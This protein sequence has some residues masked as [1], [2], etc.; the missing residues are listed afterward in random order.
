MATR[1][2]VE[3][4]R[5]N[6]RRS[7][8]PRTPEGKTIASRNATTLGLFTRELLL[9]DE[10]PGELEALRE[11][12]HQ[13]LRPTGVIERGC[14]ERYIVATWRLQRIMGAEAKIIAR[15]RTAG[16][17]SPADVLSNPDALAELEKLQ[18]HIS[19]LERA[20]DRA[21]NMLIKLQKR[22]RGND[23]ADRTRDESANAEIE[24]NS[25]PQPALEAHEPTEAR[26]EVDLAGEPRAS[27]PIEIVKTKP[28]LPARPS[29]GGGESRNH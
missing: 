8:G 19:S 22:R 28:I 2:Q 13:Q 7:T 27:S 17:P 16:W 23:R 29:A 6:A 15:W 1:R 3:A 24:A 12:T 5:L 18:K 20:I 14:V 21:L 10:D 26:M 25:A 9:V 4:N 11:E